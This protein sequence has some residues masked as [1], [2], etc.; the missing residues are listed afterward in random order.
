MSWLT[1][2]EDGHVVVGGREPRRE[3]VAVAGL[4]AQQRR[5]RRVP[6]LPTAAAGVAAQGVPLELVLRHASHD[7]A[8][9]RRRC[10]RE[11]GV[12]EERVLSLR[13]AQ[14]RQVEPARVAA[15]VRD[16]ARKQLERVAAAA[17]DE[18]LVDERAAIVGGRERRR[19]VAPAAELVFDGDK[20]RAARHLAD[21][22][23]R[24]RRR[25]L[26]MEARLVPLDHAAQ[27]V[28]PLHQNTSHPISAPLLPSQQAKQRQ[29]GEMNSR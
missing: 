11:A 25:R 3:V 1:R 17:A 29:S 10:L 18:H 5:R 8:V 2:S 20:G 22:S 28:R 12:G 27:R 15:M 21:H 23:F 26:A 9:E 4:P 13:H 6:E 19:G 14:R 7:V 24:L 16:A